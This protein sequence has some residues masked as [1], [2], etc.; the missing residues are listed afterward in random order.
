MKYF[1][2]ILIVL[3]IKTL[4]Q[5]KDSIISLESVTIKNNSKFL[6]L[7]SYFRS[8]IIEN[9]KLVDYI[10]GESF[11]LYPKKDYRKQENIKSYIL[12]YRNFFN[13]EE[14]LNQKNISISFK[15]N[16]Y[17]DWK[18]PKYNVFENRK[19]LHRE[20]ILKNQFNI[21]NHSDSLVGSYIYGDDI[22]SLKSE[23]NYTF[24]KNINVNL[25]RFEK[26]DKNEVPISIVLKQKEK[27]LKNKKEIFTEIFILKSNYNYLE[28]KKYYKNIDFNISKYQNQYWDDY[29]I[30]FPLPKEIS[31]KLKLLKE[32]GN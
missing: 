23:I 10:D 24:K 25:K 26:W 28:N 32:R 21:Y 14:N 5:N 6:V 30:K 31:E 22:D 2:A 16:Y 19:T 4:G 13:Q 11:F 15:S 8:W 17:G 20:E 12:N 1:L 18:I 3:S 27:F 29:L 9:E 7:K